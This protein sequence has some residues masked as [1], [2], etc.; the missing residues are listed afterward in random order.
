MKQQTILHS[1]AIKGVGLHTGATVTICLQP[2]A[3]NQG[4]K[5]QRIDLEDKP[6]IAADVNKVTATNRGTVIQTG[7]AS[8]STI[9]HLLSALVAKGIDNVLIE[10]DGPEVPILDGSA[11]YFLELIEKAGI[12]VQEA[13]RSVLDIEEM[14]YFKDEATG[15]EYTAYP[16]EEYAVTTII[17]FKSKYICQQSAILNK[18]SEYEATIAPART[19]VFLHELMPLINQNLIKGGDL[20]NAV[21]IVEEIPSDSDLQ[22]LADKLQKPNIAVT[23]EGVLNSTALRFPNEPARHK[24][25][26]VIGDLA[27]LGKSIKGKIVATKPGHTSNVEFVKFLKKYAL[28]Q[29]KKIPKYNPNQQP[30]LDVVQIAQMLPHRYPFLLVDKI[31]ELAAD[32]V[33]GVKNVTFNEHFFQGHFPNNPVMP[34]VLQIEAMAQVGGILAL[35]TVP[36]PSNWDTYFLKID[37]TKFKQKVVPG[38]TLIF[39]L[40]LLEPIRRGIV[41]MKGSAFVGNKLVSE[42]HLTAQIVR[43]TTNESTS[44]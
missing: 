44:A 15:A 12:V 17:D 24:A 37:E 23:N 27:L 6:T 13:N 43:R 19:F 14:L 8:V 7:T 30:I 10:I 2:A 41:V 3:E 22:Y 25:L 38:D 40:E 9:E 20:D 34:G 42:A 11:I 36:D 28:E 16:S 39:K 4:I 32:K 18:I 29:S 31:I 26:D 1:Q 33:V 21:V 35:T 5:F